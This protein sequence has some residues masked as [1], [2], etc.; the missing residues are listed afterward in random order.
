MF[1]LRSMNKKAPVIKSGK[2]ENSRMTTLDLSFPLQL[3][4]AGIGKG[5][6]V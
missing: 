4:S 3:I 2:K 6:A 5:S 1:S